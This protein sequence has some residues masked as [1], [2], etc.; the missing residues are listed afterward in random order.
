ML[1]TKIFQRF[2]KGQVLQNENG[3]LNNYSGN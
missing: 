2:N 3:E 1:Y